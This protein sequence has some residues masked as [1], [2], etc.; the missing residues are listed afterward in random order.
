MS[1]KLIV[2]LVGIVAFMAI[3]LFV[4]LPKPAY[5]GGVIIV[6]QP[7]GSQQHCVLIGNICKVI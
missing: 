6:I 2:T 7:D 1:H 5:A 4:W 3:N